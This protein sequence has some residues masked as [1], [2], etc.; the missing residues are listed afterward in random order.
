MI[1]L[2]QLKNS[3]NRYSRERKKKEKRTNS[4]KEIFKEAIQYFPELNDRN[5]QIVETQHNV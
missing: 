2:Y 1:K 3:N 4:E 5:F